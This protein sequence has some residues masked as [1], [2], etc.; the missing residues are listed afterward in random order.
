MM[1]SSAAAALRSAKRVLAGFPRR[2]GDRGWTRA[3][4]HQR[5]GVVNPFA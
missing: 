2:G 4:L 3:E 5:G 1:V